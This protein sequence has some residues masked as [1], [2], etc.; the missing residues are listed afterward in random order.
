MQFVIQD[1]SIAHDFSLIYR[2]ED[3][4]FD[5]E[6]HDDT[7]F[8]SILIND[9]QLE[10][11]EHGLIQYVWGLCPLIKFTE[12]D[13]FPIS[14]ESHPLLAL[15]EESPTPGI[16]IR[17]NENE[18][19]PIYVNKI[20]G[21]VCIGNPKASGSYIEFVPNCVAVLDKQEIITVWLKPK[22]Y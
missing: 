3:Y 22:F 5:R 15:L 21:W 2:E 16:S 7:G 18:R 10:I 13:R 17:I 1:K 14:Y 11:D 20:K 6:P 19:W 12:T 4:S 9:L 8:T